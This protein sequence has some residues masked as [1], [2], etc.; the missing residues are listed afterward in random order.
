MTGTPLFPPTRAV[1]LA[2]I[3]AVRPSEYA[4]TRN[5][6]EG[7]V[8]HLSPYITHGL[9]TLPDVVAGVAAKHRL[10]VGHKLVFELGWRAYF[11]HIW[12]HQG[13]GIFQ[14][15]HSGPQPDSA[16]TAALPGL[17]QSGGAYFATL[18]ALNT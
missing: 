6:I 3:E 10:S 9:I 7:A 16:Y 15:L 1:A 12:H 5:A 18:S 4:R 14:S 8:T 2:R 17:C 11:R 13:D